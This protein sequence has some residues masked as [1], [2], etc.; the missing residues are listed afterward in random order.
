MKKRYILINCFLILIL[1]TGCQKNISNEKENKIL[2]GEEFILGQD[3][4]P[5]FLSSNIAFSTSE[6]G[7]YILDWKLEYFDWKSKSVVPVPK[8]AVHMLAGGLMKFYI[9]KIIYIMRDLHMP[10]RA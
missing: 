10:K 6:D 8:N 9:M 1:L 2:K 3:D 7:Y 4:Q 5:N